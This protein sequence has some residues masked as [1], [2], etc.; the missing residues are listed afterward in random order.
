M[1][2][3]HARHVNQRYSGTANWDR[4]KLLKEKLNIPVTGNGDITSP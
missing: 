3:L 4:I 2:A 1:I